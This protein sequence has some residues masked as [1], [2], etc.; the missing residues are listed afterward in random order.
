MAMVDAQI[1]GILFHLFKGEWVT[2]LELPGDRIRFFSYHDPADFASPD[3]PQYTS[4][5]TPPLPKQDVSGS[6]PVLVLAAEP[7]IR[8]KSETCVLD[9]VFHCQL[10][11]PALYVRD[12]VTE[13][14]QPGALDQPPLNDDEARLLWCACVLGALERSNRIKPGCTL[15]FFDYVIKKSDQLAQHPAGPQ[16]RIPVGFRENDYL[17]GD[18]PAWNGQLTQLLVQREVGGKRRLP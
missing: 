11:G 4:L 16:I 12:F 6:P 13:V 14:L 10:T 17:G 1:V 7:G 18:L 9:A 8:P 2:N 3:F 5:F 15:Q